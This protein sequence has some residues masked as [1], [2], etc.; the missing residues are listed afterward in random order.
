M[1]VNTVRGEKVGEYVTR[2]GGYFAVNDLK[3]GTYTVFELETL[4]DY[5]L[6]STPQTVELV[7]GHNAELTFVNQPRNAL[8]IRKT[9]AVTGKPLTGI[10]FE[11]T[12]LNGEKVGTYTTA[13]GQAVVTGLEPGAYIVRE[14]QTIPGYVLDATPQTVE[15]L[16]GKSAV[17]EFVNVPL[18]GLQIQKV[19]SVTGVSF[20]V[21]HI[22]GRLIG[23]FI[24]DSNGYIHVPGLEE[25]W[26][27]M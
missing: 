27:E 15:L 26:I 1:Q 17:V 16:P 23:S 10:R 13:N 19:D 14:T 24:T 22:D 18:V 12:K 3:P 21:K 20:D 6:D 5:V 25:G 11:V 9:D 7:E 8:E 4:P 2:E